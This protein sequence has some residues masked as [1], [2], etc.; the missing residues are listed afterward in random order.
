MHI[1]TRVGLQL[2]GVAFFI[3]GV[4]GFFQF[5]ISLSKSLPAI[6]TAGYGLLTLAGFFCA[7]YCNEKSKKIKAAKEA[8]VAALSFSGNR[9]EADTKKI[10]LLLF[11]ILLMPLILLFPIAVFITKIFTPFT[12]GGSLFLLLMAIALGAMLLS[13]FRR[14]KPMLAMDSFGLDHGWYGM[15]RWDQIHGIFLQSV[16]IKHSIQHTLFLGVSRPGQYLKNTPWLLRLFTRRKTMEA[17]FG[18]L[19][20]PLNFLNQPAQLVHAATLD[21]RK[22]VRTPL[23][24]GWYPDMSPEHVSLTVSGN[25]NMAR[26]D[27]INAAIK[28][29]AEITPAMENE[30]LELLKQTQMFVEA[31]S[32]MRLGDIKKTTRLIYVSLGIT[33]TSFFL[34]LLY[35]LFFKYC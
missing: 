19:N 30:M 32:S 11:M 6:V 9:F 16:E 22:R 8:A 4:Y 35:I 10:M 23:L 34:W 7:V 3:A 20:I 1:L 25:A 29:G 17:D 28:T 27:E 18:S 26:M 13:Y 12:V 2:L 33:L 14:G 15:I 31:D 24:D 5:F 21:L